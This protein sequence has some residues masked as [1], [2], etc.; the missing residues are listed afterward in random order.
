MMTASSSEFIGAL[1]TQTGGFIQDLVPLGVFALALV[2]AVAVGI[3]IYQIINGAF[4]RVL[5]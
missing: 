4:K 3:I 5:K 1:L 2:V